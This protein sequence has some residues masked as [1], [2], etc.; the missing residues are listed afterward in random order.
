MEKKPFEEYRRV[1]KEFTEPSLTRQSEAG[2]TDVNKIVARHRKTGVVTH[3][4]SK[5]PMYGDFSAADDLHRAINLTLAAQEGFMDLPSA[6]R[7]AADN[8]PRILLEMLAD[9]EG[10]ELLV[11]A[12]LVID[13]QAEADERGIPFAR[14]SGGESA[15]ETEGSS[16]QK[17]DGAQA[18]ESAGTET[19]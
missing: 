17:P 14:P 16:P 19:T 5:P 13:D 11:E 1:R 2:D 4:N 18:T 15:A 3:L 9:E 8:D 12:G 6:V 7:R 10:R